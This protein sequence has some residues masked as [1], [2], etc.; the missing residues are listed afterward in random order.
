MLHG[1]DERGIERWFFELASMADWSMFPA[2]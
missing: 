2:S 1:S